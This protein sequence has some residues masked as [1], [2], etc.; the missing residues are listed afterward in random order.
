MGITWEYNGENAA[1]F[2]I[3]YL[4][5]FLSLYWLTQKQ[6]FYGMRIIRLMYTQELFINK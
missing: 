5:E 3:R 4:T 2:S 1:I 6:R